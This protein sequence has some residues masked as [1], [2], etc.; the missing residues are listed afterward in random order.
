MPWPI[1]NSSQITSCGDTEEPV[2]KKFGLG[3]HEICSDW[4][5]T[6]SCWVCY[7]QVRRKVC[8]TTNALIVTYNSKF[9][10]KYCDIYLPCLKRY[11]DQEVFVLWYHC[12]F[13][14]CWYRFLSYLQVFFWL[15]NAKLKFPTFS[16]SWFHR[17]IKDCLF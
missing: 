7:A 2:V 5:S 17:P 12:S 9:G 8:Q 1:W 6:R 14:C 4:N 15:S 13:I 16:F 10:H 11:V 3:S